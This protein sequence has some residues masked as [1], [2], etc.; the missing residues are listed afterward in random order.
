MYVSKY[1]WILLQIDNINNHS[2]QIVI[3]ILI[4]HIMTTDWTVSCID[5]NSVVTVVV[6]NDLKSSAFVYMSKDM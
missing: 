1:E 2:M 3:L 6:M 5:M 4:I